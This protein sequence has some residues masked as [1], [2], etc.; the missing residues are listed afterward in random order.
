MGRIIEVEGY[1]AFYG[2]MWICEMDRLDVVRGGWLY[3]PDTGCW[4]CGGKSYP[5]EICR[6]FV[7]E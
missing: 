7:V 5:R 2:S 4:Y 1:Q 6:I 3:K